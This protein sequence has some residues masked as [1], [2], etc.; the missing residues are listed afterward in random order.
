[1]QPQLQGAY[2]QPIKLQEVLIEIS[3]NCNLSCIMCGFKKE[4][5]DKSKFMSFEKFRFIFEKIKPYT[6]MVRLNGRGES[7]IHKD[8]IRICEYVNKAGLDISLFTNANFKQEKILTMFSHIQ[9]QLF[10]SLDSPDSINAESIRIG[11]KF[12]NI[13]NNLSKLTTLTK[14]PFIV[15]TIQEKNWYEIQAIGEFA[16]NF[17]CGII[18]N[19]IKQDRNN[20]FKKL[21]QSNLTKIQDMFHAIKYQYNTT[22][23]QA[24]IPDQILGIEI[25]QTQI[26]CGSKARC[27]NIQKELCIQ[28]DG[29]VIPCNMFNP[30]KLGNIFVDSLEEILYGKKMMHFLATHKSNPYCKNCA[31]LKE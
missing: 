13:I 27:P 3:Q 25:S 29:D 6:T 10:I 8:F 26:S 21:I 14:R 5:N 24:L 30:Y 4:N 31:C 12:E 17:Q 1:M 15:F 11:S 23:L 9:P 7:T 19:V 20:N 2:M 28:Y 16:L 22:N 18:Y